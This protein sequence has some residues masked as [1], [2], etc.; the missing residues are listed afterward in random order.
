MKNFNEMWKGYL[1]EVDFDTSNLSEKY[2]KSPK[3]KVDQ[4]I[5]FI[6]RIFS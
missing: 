1:A 3:I 2:N 6:S 4:A 5:T